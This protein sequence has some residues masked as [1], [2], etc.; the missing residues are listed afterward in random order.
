M[1]ATIVEARAW[2]KA[3]Q[4]NGSF[5]SSRFSG[6]EE[7]LDFVYKLYRGGAVNV[8]ID[9]PVNGPSPTL[10]IE[11]PQDTDYRARLLEVLN[12]EA[13]RRGSPLSR[14]EGQGNIEIRWE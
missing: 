4:A 8:W 10:V 11:M 7:A 14:E 1:N 13:A 5:R 2:L 12:S 6:V 9:A 3:T